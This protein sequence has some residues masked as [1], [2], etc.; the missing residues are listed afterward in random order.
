MRPG[1]VIAPAAVSACCI[2]CC[3]NRWPKNPIRTVI[4]YQYVDHVDTLT[5]RL[6]IDSVVIAVYRCASYAAL[7]QP[8]WVVGHMTTNSKAVNTPGYCR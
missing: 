4:N 6:K 3:T 2:E 7:L 1:C 8:G 5:L